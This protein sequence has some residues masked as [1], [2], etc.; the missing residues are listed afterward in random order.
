MKTYTGF[1]Y[2][3]G[4]RFKL[5]TG[6]QI[7]EQSIAK[8]FKSYTTTNANGDIGF[9]NL[10]QTG[11]AFWTYTGDINI[12]ATKLA[13]AFTSFSGDI[14]GTVT[15][16]GI[17]ISGL[18]DERE[19][20]FEEKFDP[21][22]ITEI[23]SIVPGLEDETEDIFEDKFDPDTGTEIRTGTPFD[24]DIDVS[25][26][27]NNGNRM[28]EINADAGDDVVTAYTLQSFDLVSVSG[29]AGDDTYHASFFTPHTSNA[30]AFFA[31]GQGRDK[32]VLFKDAEESFTVAEGSQG[33]IE[34]ILGGGNKFTLGA[35]TEV[36]TSMNS[37]DYSGVSLQNYLVE[38]LFA[39]RVRA[40]DNNELTARTTGNNVDWFYK[41]LDTYTAYHNN[42]VKPDPEPT[43]APQPEPTPA[44]QPEP[45][46]YDG[47]IESIR[48][49]G[50]LK[51]TDVAD[52][53]TFN[54]LDVFS[55]KAADK[56]IGFSS[57]QG[58][59]IVISPEAFPELQG[60]SEIDFAS[61][62]NKK[63]LKLLSKQDYDFVYFEKKGRLYYDG[64]G[65]DKNWGNKDEGGLFAV[66][67]GKPELTVDDFTVLA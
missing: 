3:A 9:F 22:A 2:L 30:T 27:Y 54:S 26:S 21:G 63:E 8:G 60:S 53:F 19:G 7:T 34:I 58:D 25:G 67:K 31:G 64:N 49:K 45:E 32:S 66:L 48:G 55:K 16:L 52:A 43:P 11:D 15:E 4:I 6:L 57:V 38:D 36:F 59:S 24:D 65:A 12:S 5:P 14:T 37:G 61:T 50:K 44:P 56:I 35:D 23:G 46:P 10:T 20:F 42:I 33:F 40:V 29:G 51:G 62:K 13:D 41:G 39:G 1:F 18:E 28:I 17:I 47:I